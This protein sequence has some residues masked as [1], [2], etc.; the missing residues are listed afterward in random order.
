MKRLMI[1]VPCFN[2]QE[3]FENTLQQLSNLL[4]DLIKRQKIAENS[5]ILFVDDGSTD[6]TRQLITEAHQKYSHI[7]GVLLAANVGHQN[8]LVAGLEVAADMCDVTITIDADLQD[9]IFAIEQMLDKFEGGCDIV[10]GVRSDR[11]TDSFF[12]RTTAEFF[13]KFMHSLGVKTVNNHADFRLLS[14]RATKQLLK[15]TERNL[16]LRGIVTE[17]GYKTD[18]VYYKR[19]KRTAGK[20]KYSPPKMIKFAWEGITSFSIRP[21]KLIMALGL[22][23]MLCSFLALCYVLASYFFRNAGGGWPSLMISIWFLGGVQLFSIGVVGQYIG[24]IYL[25]TKGRPRYNIDEILNHENN[26]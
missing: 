11:K 4:F 19:Q 5:G 13:Y 16:F 26:E 6:N 2:E 21:M 25:E 24:K 23:I 3:V 18:C 15:Y 9:D 20:T 12:K 7:Y 10:Y 1:I 8:A 14:V 22:V 17:L